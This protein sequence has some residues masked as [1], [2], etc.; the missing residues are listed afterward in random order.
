MLSPS[1]DPNEFPVFGQLDRAK[2]IDQRNDFLKHIEDMSKD[3]GVDW[4]KV[5]ISEKCVFDIIEMIEKRRV[6]FHVFHNGMDMGEINEACLKCFWLLKL[7]PFTNLED[8]D[9]KIN[10]VFAVS[11]FT[12][13]LEYRE[14][15][16]GR[17]L[18]VTDDF[19]KHLIHAFAFRDL[20]KEAIMAI[21]ESLIGA[22]EPSPF[23]ALPV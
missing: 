5:A 20:S 10:L 19:V 13:T 12:R 3:L 11:L 2:Y 15:K 1:I 6:Y 14:K 8:P 22:G 18:R 17:K 7:N 23:S 9:Y 21:A 4:S 16:K